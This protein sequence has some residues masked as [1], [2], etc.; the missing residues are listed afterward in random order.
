MNRDEF[1]AN[2]RQMRGQIKRWWGILDDFDLD[3]TDGKSERLI[4]LIQHK[5]GYTRV[6]AEEE[7]NL[8]LKETV[9]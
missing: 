1:E 7:F 5:Y 9:V 3:R 4:E 8:W 2:W 6:H